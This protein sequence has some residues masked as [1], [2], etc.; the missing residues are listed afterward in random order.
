RRTLVRLVP[1]PVELFPRLAPL[2]GDLLS[3]D[4]LHHDVVPLPDE[5]GH[6][7][8]VRPHRDARHHLDAARDDEAELARPDGGGRVEVRLHRGAAL[9]IDRRPGHRNRPA[10][11]ERDVAADVPRLLVDL[12]D[13]PPLHI[14]DL[15]RIDAVPTHER[16][17]DLRRE[18]VATDV[19]ERAVLLPDGAT[20]GVDD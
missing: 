20:D 12:R 2:L 18:L 14:L 17:D 13:A 8:V 15:G 5:R 3:G 7:T 19:R 10:G 6:R 9:A 11:R 4:A 16:I 1:D